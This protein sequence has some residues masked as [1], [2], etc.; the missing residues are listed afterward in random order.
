MEAPFIRKIVSRT[1]L[2]KM[3]TLTT[4]MARLKSGYR[5]QKIGFQKEI[6]RTPAG[7]A[8]MSQV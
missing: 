5:T 7:R 1:F 6:S 2:N 4:R 3:R 8:P